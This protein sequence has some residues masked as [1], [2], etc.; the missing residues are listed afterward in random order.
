MLVRVGFVGGS[1]FALNMWHANIVHA[2]ESSATQRQ[3]VKKKIR[4]SEVSSSSATNFTCFTFIF[5]SQET[6][7]V[8]LVL[9][10][11]YL[12]YKLIRSNAENVYW[13]KIISCEF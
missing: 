10:T 6:F 3:P 5:L 13:K 1:V 7:H 9:S 4:P 11:G 2:A 8:K 12:W